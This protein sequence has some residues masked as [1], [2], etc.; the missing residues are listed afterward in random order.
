MTT[1]RNAT[2]NVIRAELMRRGMTLKDFATKHGFIPQSVCKAIDRHA[3]KESV[4]RGKITFRILETI[5]Q[6]ISHD[7]TETTVSS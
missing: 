7:G 3:G 5:H 4:P 1:L 2:K 6:E